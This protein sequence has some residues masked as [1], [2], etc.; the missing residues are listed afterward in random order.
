MAEKEYY[1]IKNPLRRDGTS[2][3][4]RQ[5]AA[6]DPDFVKVDDRTTQ[7]FFNFASFLFN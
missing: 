5:E 1:N 4:Q 2:Q 6:L 7:D 3:N